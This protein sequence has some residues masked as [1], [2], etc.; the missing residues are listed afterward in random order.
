MLYREDTSNKAP[1]HTT[2]RVAYGIQASLYPSQPL[3]PWQPPVH[4]HLFL[5]TLT[6]FHSWNHKTPRFLETRA[7]RYA[8]CSSH[9]I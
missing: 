1:I 4:Q 8:S 9:V 5:S 7:R 6:S 3:L 2:Q